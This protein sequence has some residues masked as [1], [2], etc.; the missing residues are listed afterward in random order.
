MV[1]VGAGWIRPLG[2]GVLMALWAISMPSVAATPAQC[3]PAAGGSPKCGEAG[4]ASTGTQQSQVGAGNP[5]NVLTGNKYQ[6]EVDLAP[7]PGVLGLELVRHY[8]SVH[9]TPTTPNGLLGRGWRL[10][11][12]TR[13]YPKG[14]L[15]EVVQADGSRLGFGRDWRNP[16]V[17]SPA[18]PEHGKIFIEGQGPQTRYQW[19]W[20]DGRRLSFNAAGLLQQIVAPSGEILSLQYDPRGL[21]IK[22][23]DPQGR[24]LQLNYLERDRRDGSRFSGVQSIDSPV[25]RFEYQYGSPAIAAKPAQAATATSP[26]TPATPAVPAQPANLV[27]VKLPTHYD[28]DTTAH[29][30][31]SRGTTRSSLT[32]RYHHEDPRHPTLLTGI[33]VVG[34]GSD[35]KPMQVRLSRYAYDERGWAIRSERDGAVLELSRIERAGLRQDTERPSGVAVLVHSKTP[36]QPEGQQLTVYSSQVVGQYRIVRTEG[37]P[38]P[39]SLDCPQ[40]NV[41]YRYDDQGRLIE[42]TEL[43]RTADGST[44]PLRS[45]RTRY[46]PLGR[47]LRISQHA[48]RPG[49]PRQPDIELSY[50]RYEYGAELPRHSLPQPGQHQ[51]QG[52]QPTLIARPSVVPGQEH[53]LRLSHNEHG[54][55]LQVTEVGY[56]P[57]DAQGQP[58]SRPQDAQRI[59]RS[60]HYS[61]SRLN[62]RSVLSQ[63]DGP[64]PG[65]A[66]TVRLQWDARGDHL[67]ALQL[68]LG[69]QHRWTQ[70][71]DAG[72]V[73]KEVPPDGVAITH[74][75]LPTGEPSQWQRGPATAQVRFDALMRPV[76][77]ELPDGEVQSLAYDSATQAVALATNRGQMRWVVPPTA[78]IS[79]PVSAPTLLPAA[80]HRARHATND[81]WS[82]SRGWVDD[83]GRLVALVTPQTGLEQRQYDEANR[84]IRRTLA[85][86]SQWRWQRD[87]LGRI[88]AH[89]VQRPG[90]PEVKTTLAYQG[91]RLVSIQHPQEHEQLAYDEWGRISERRIS[92]G[93]T[94]KQ[95]SLQAVDRYE[96]DQADRLSA[97]HLPE[98]GSLRYEWGVGRQLKAVQHQDG[99]VQAV[100]GRTVGDWLATQWGVGQR[101]V[102]KPLETVQSTNTKAA[103]NPTA[104]AAAN[105]DAFALPAML[106]A[107]QGYRWGNGVALRWQLNAQGQLAQMRWEQPQSSGTGWGAWLTAWLPQAQATAAT[108]MP[109]AGKTPKTPPVL[110]QSAFSYD[111]LGRMQTRTEADLTVGYAYDRL[112]RLL[113]AQ[114]QGAATALQPEFYAYDAQGALQVARLQGQDHDWRGQRIERDTT[115]LPLRLSD[116]RTLNYSADRRLS[117]VRQGDALLARYTHNT[118]GLRIAK[119]VYEPGQA[120]STASTPQGR[121]TQY[122]WQ[123]MTLVAETAPT[124][125]GGSREGASAPRLARRYVYAHQVPVA[126]IDYEEG[127]E[128]RAPESTEGLGAWFTALW[129][130]VSQQPG[131]LRF[132]HANEIGTPVAVTDAQARLIWRAKPTTYTAYGVLKASSNGGDAAHT[133][134]TP[135]GFALNLRLPG[136]YFDAETGWHDNVLR[137]YDPQRAQYLEPDPLGPL[138]NWRST[139]LLTQPYA[140]ANHNP[141]T[142]ADPTGLILFA[143]DGTGNSNHQGTLNELGNGLSNVVNFFELYNSGNRRYVSGVGTRHFD[144]QYGDIHLTWGNTSTVDMGLNLT[145]R[146]RIERM[147][148]YFND[149]A[150]L[151]LDDEVMDVDVIGFSRGASQA[152]EFANRIVA[153]TRDG[154]YSYTVTGADGQAQTKCQKVNFRFMGLWDTVLSTDLPWGTYQLAIPAEFRY[155]AHAVALNEHRGQPFRQLN[156]SIGAFPLESI[157]GSPQPVGGGVRIERGFLGAHADIGGGF[158][159][160]KN[161]LARV[162]LTWMVEQAKL[163]GVRMNAPREDI[164]A[165]PI[166]HDKSDNQYARDV[167]ERPA[168]WDEDREVRYMNGQTTTQRRMTGT[169]MTHED[170]LRY[171]EFNA[172]GRTQYNIDTGMV[173]YAPKPED[174]SVGTVD[175]AGYLDWLRR[176]GYTMGNLRVQ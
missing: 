163:S 129:R 116:G 36:Q 138:P 47:V 108:A 175:M 104:K 134:H 34:N 126:V 136:Q 89:T 85:D 142:Y 148:Q 11:Y 5:I 22:V 102:I 90:Q 124:S 7:L 146:D 151:A 170:T 176:N 35:G 73:V 28:A 51:L 59:E 3:G 160:G 40:A 164:I 88:V 64:L 42:Q 31:T 12:E 127:A 173:E 87:A 121:H 14:R 122:L 162:A 13:L 30:Y 91:P 43:A 131:E 8:N 56:S 60:T 52:R 140:Y 19:V 71:D 75:H 10:S 94:N 44:I 67:Q 38:C 55:V 130:W 110:M 66:D 145:G 9:S 77:I 2:L 153:N 115:G 25:G 32:R 168:G 120:T 139:R 15:L 18:S 70:R 103:T 33:S 29:I 24:S 79:P 155:V 23:T 83:W 147:Q 119:T 98:G 128:L 16:A 58:A 82:G 112:G 143:F 157:T 107:E 20:A 26:A 149:E 62:G 54:Q 114:P 69:L 6:R 61:Y 53:Q 49:Q 111:A 86:Q 80:A 78:T 113:V 158:E 109:G 101:P 156:G 100:L 17:C 4:P 144:S 97:W 106:Q 46:D 133:A 68:P 132:I 57:L 141:I 99:Q 172:G 63:I 166:I 123:G 41:R 72:R 96:Y 167:G 76:R 27:A 137:T 135:K 154:W 169:G 39:A 118:H 165:T 92:R 174:A 93:V 117:E 45:T 171:I 48:H 105:D 81:P 1:I 161:D 74:Q 84:P 37:V 21:L 95:P 50:V 152:R 65:P 159:E 150:E 125:I